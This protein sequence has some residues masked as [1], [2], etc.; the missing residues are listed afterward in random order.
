MNNKKSFIAINMLIALGI[1]AFVLVI[2]FFI[3]P[4]LLG[5]GAAE[6]S[7]FLSASKDYDGDG[8]ANLWDKCACE[9]GYNE[10]DGCKN[11]KDMTDKNKKNE[12]KESMKNKNN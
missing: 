2:F 5:E 8:I 12:C 7:D 6:A 10:F 11:T 1:G 3:L 9:S 4:K